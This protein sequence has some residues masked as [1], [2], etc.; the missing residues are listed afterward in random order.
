MEVQIRNATNADAPAISRTIVDA[1]R[2]SNAQDYSSDIIDQLVQDFSPAAVLQRMTGRHVLVAAI[3]SRI[4]ATASLDNNVVRS[5]FVDPIHQGRGIGRHLMERIQSIAMDMGLELLCV[6][7]SI[8]AEG[9]Y[10]SLGF[11][12]IRDEFHQSE[13][14]VVMTKT[15]QR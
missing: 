9:F 13:R 15:L 5:V 12:K 14:T 1:L 11:K 6:P 10:A 3:D 7:S 8:T 2:E 4:V